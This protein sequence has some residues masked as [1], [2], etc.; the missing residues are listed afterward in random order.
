MMGLG[1]L[2]NKTP[3][4]GFRWMLSILSASQE[5]LRRAEIPSGGEAG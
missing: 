1:V 5:S 4:L 2:S 3:S